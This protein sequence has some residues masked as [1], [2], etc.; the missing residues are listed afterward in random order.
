MPPSLID[1]HGKVT[2][3]FV[4][5]YGITIPGMAGNDDKQRR[6]NHNGQTQQ[7][8]YG[9]AGNERTPARNSSDRSD[10]VVA[11]TQDPVSPPAVE[12]GDL[13]QTTMIGSALDLDDVDSGEPNDADAVN[14]QA[15][16][17]ASHAGS[18]VGL[19][20]LSAV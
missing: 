6:A 4:R 12:N 10:F 13:D 5:E 11:S 17:S 7:P 20:K 18:Q 14:S 8:S 2:E 16:A 19:L 15:S 9:A 1:P 3:E